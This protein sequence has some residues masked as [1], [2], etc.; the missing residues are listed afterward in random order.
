MIRTKIIGLVVFVLLFVM[1]A[2]GGRYI[3]YRQTDPMDLVTRDR[4]DQQI[5]ALFE[6]FD[7]EIQAD[8]V[9]LVT[10]STAQVVYLE[11]KYPDVGYCILITLRDYRLSLSRYRAVPTTDS[12]F[13]ITKA[14]SDVGTIQYMTIRK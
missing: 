1:V 7:R 9:L 10:G 3:T 4:I 14:S 12:S 8:T 6:R 13:T 5:D 2:Y 11:R